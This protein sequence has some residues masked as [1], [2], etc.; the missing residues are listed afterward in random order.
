M[1]GS[2][3]A[4]LLILAVVAQL[5]DR[6]EGHHP[7]P[8]VDAHASHVMPAARYASA[9]RVAETYTKAAEIVSVIDGLYC[10]CFC[11]ETFGHY[12]LLDC[13]K[14]DHGAGCEVCLR[15]VEIAYDMTQRGSSL[16]EI[17]QTIDTTFGRT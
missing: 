17:R 5:G 13:F 9:P 16:D 3:L 11:R 2:V 8:R 4:A 1:G 15:E 6:G 12:S 7:T 10:H 14:D